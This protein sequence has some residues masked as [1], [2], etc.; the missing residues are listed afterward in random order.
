MAERRCFLDPEIQE[1]EGGPRPHEDV[2]EQV[3]LLRSAEGSRMLWEKTIWGG[4]LLS[5]GGLRARGKA[6]GRLSGVLPLGGWFP[7]SAPSVK[8]M[9]QFSGLIRWHES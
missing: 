6:G 8:N 7:A 1:G 5:Y 2:T 9:L 3:R 4:F